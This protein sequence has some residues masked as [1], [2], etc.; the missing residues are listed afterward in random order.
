MGSGFCKP[1]Q[2]YALEF[3]KMQK[4]AELTPVHLALQMGL[5]DAKQSRCSAAGK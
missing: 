4:I 3:R 5:R 2:N 1:L